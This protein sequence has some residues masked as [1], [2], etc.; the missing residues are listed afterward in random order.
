MKRLP[1]NYSIC[2]D[3]YITQSALILGVL[4][5]G[6]VVLGNPNRSVDTNR[7]V[8]FLKSLGGNIKRHD[9]EIRIEGGSGLEVPEDLK[10]IY[11]GAIFPLS[12]VIGLLA[13]LN[14][15]CLL[16]YAHSINQDVVDNIIDAF[17]H[18]GVDILHESDERLIVFRSG[19][20]HPLELD[21]VS[22]LPYLRNSMLM[23]GLSSGQGVVIR[24]LVFGSDY[25]IRT[26]GLFDAGLIVEE[27]RPELV[28]D[29]IDPRKKIRSS[30]TG[31]KRELAI[32]RAPKLQPLALDIPADSDISG[33]LISLA[34][35]KGKRISLRNVSLNSPMMRFLDFLKSSGAEIEISGRKITGGLPCGF[36]SI[37]PGEL[38]LRRISGA[39]AISLINDIAFVALLAAFYKGTTV[40]RGIEEFRDCG[41]EPMNEIADNIGRLGAKCGVLKDGLVVDGTGQI[42]GAD[43]GPFKNAKI[44]L[45]FYVAALA[46]QEN[47][48]FSNF[49]IVSEHYP[50]FVSITADALSSGVSTVDQAWL[51][52]ES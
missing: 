32:N 11:G 47:S 27:T 34:V 42:N 45:A 4:A 5:E 24:E 37:L 39:Q 48:S 18:N 30:G 14:Q 1:E 44:A 35:L 46:G 31:H 7:T 26:L 38:K 19:R 10:L 36:V 33:A 43:L 52:R 41:L 51:G 16:N 50:N 29:P 21:T 22:A 13:G 9:S 20:K 12:L 28:R 2:G 3:Y 17:N 49:E 15:S 23:Y 6:T 25:F 8:V 40:I